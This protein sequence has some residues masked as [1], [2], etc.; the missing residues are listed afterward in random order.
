MVFMYFSNPVGVR[1]ERVLSCRLRRK[2]E[3]A[4]CDEHEDEAGN[5]TD[6]KG[7][8]IIVFVSRTVAFFFICHPS[9]HSCLMF[10]KICL[11]RMYTFT[12]H[13]FWAQTLGIILVTLLRTEWAETDDRI[14]E[15]SMIATD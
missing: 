6:S 5:P 15:K 12:A 1:W 4:N 13:V 8:L 7:A 9:L 14:A 2:S 11:Y 3:R 10:R